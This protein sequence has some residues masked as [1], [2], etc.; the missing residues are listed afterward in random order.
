MA[1]RSNFCAT[2]CCLIFL[3][4]CFPSDEEIDNPTN[5]LDGESS[6]S[7]SFIEIHHRFLRSPEILLVETVRDSLHCAHHCLV[8]K[9]CRSFNFGLEADNNGRHLCQLLPWDKF[10]YSGRYEPSSAF[11]HYR[12]AVRYKICLVCS[13]QYYYRRVAQPVTDCRVGS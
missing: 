1:P 12:I 8:T 10:Q 9:T 11:H 5:V 2:L 6:R 4:N 13:I 3:G 7:A